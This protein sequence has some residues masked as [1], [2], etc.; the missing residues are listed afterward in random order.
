MHRQ[1]GP[2]VRSEIAKTFGLDKSYLSRLMENPAYSES[3]R[4]KTYFKLTQNYRSHPGQ[5][6]FM[7]ACIA[8]V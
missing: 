6:P 7:S 3:Y 2:I 1:L 5:Y 8:D 4:N